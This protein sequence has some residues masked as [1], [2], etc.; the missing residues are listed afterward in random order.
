MIS[1]KDWEYHTKSKKGYCRGDDNDPVP[2]RC[3]S[4]KTIMPI[5]LNTSFGEIDGHCLSLKGKSVFMVKEVKLISSTAIQCKIINDNNGRCE[6]DAANDEYKKLISDGWV[7]V[8]EEKAKYLL[9]PQTRFK[10]KK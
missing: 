7:R 10:D 1:E 8:S 9:H 2:R 4:A 3:D 6:K 5:V